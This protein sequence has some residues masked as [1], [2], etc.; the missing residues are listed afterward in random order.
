MNQKERKERK[1]V[2]LSTGHE[3]RYYGLS[4]E[5]AV[6]IASLHDNGDWSAWPCPT[7]IE[8]LKPRL[9]YTNKTVSYQDYCTIL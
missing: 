3:Y 1:V 8:K 2:N 5:E 6:I 7:K 4:A 9:T